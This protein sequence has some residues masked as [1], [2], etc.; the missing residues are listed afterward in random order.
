[1]MQPVISRSYFR[2]GCGLLTLLLIAVGTTGARS[3]E[4]SA[5]WSQ[6]LG[7]NRNGMSSE[8]GLLDAFPAQGPKELWRVRGGVGMSGLAVA[9]GKAVTL[10]QKAGKQ[11][12]LALDVKNGKT[13]WET[14]VAPAYRNGQGN[15]PRATPAIAGDSVFAFTGEGILVA[16]KLADGKIRWQHNTV[17]E[18]GGAVADYGMACSPLVVGDVVV[19]TPGA[20]NGGGVVAY[21]A[22]DGRLAWKTGRDT[23]GYSSPALLK[24]DGRP[25]LV[26]FTGKAAVGLNPESGKTLWRFPY[27]TD[28]DC[29]IATPIL[30]DGHVFISAGENHGCAMLQL[31]K[32]GDGYRVETA[33]KS[34]GGGSVMRNEWQTSI[35]LD[36]HLYGMDNVGG[37]GPVTN[38][39]CVDAKTGKLVW[40]KK[41]F[42]KG[43]LI[44]ADGK[45]I[46]LTMKGELVLVRATPGG[47]QE[48]SRTKSLLGST[49]QMPSL[50]DG[51]L[52]ARDGAEIV[53]WDIR[54]P[55]K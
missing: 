27:N 46:I 44:Y 2:T 34:N 43:N 8:T 11:T 21:R 17:K 45:L 33:W 52:Y 10:V 3:A 13:L 7:P 5:G 41:R 19:V 47:F 54:K 31:I 40:T 15:G 18:L 48:L 51:R 55:R 23:A 25:Q 9:G 37:A 36:G 20:N 29:N 50:V 42:G 49:R 24:I 32:S 39:N 1:M 22:A 4:K 53:C 14:A 38:L 28:Y 16:L 35:S 6:F 26:A 12:V 30:V